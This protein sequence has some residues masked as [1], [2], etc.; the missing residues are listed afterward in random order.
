MWVAPA[1]RAQKA[2]ATAETSRAKAFP[3]ETSALIVLERHNPRRSRQL[4]ASRV[5]VE[6]AF[7][8]ARD[9]TAKG[10]D[11]L[12]HLARVGTTDRVGD[13]D[14]VDANLVDGAVD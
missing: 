8:V 5:V 7:N 11:E 3:K 9:D 4:A 12:V 6:V 14:A 1:S 10:A 13:T 2:F